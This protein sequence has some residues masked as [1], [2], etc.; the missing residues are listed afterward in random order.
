MPARKQHIKCQSA[1][2]VRSDD[3]PLDAR[4]G[5]DL[6]EVEV[7]DADLHQFGQTFSGGQDVLLDAAVGGPLSPRFA[8]T[9]GM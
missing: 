4:F 7:A 2:R 9:A 6:D 5:R 8:G 3:E 1:A